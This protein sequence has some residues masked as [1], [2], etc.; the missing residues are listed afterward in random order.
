MSS[1]YS[2]QTRQNF[3]DTNW[4]ASISIYTLGLNNPRIISSNLP[5][6]FSLDYSSGIM[7]FSNISVAHNYSTQL[8]FVFQINVTSANGYNFSALSNPVRIGPTAVQ[9][10][11]TLYNM[12]LT[13]SGDYAAIVSSRQVATYTAMI[14]NLL[15]STYGI[16]FSSALS[17]SS[18]SV[19]IGATAYTADYSA[20]ADGLSNSSSLPSGLIFS[21]VNVNSVTY[22]N[23]ALAASVTAT[24]APTVRNILVFFFFISRIHPLTHL[25]FDNRDQIYQRFSE[26]RECYVFLI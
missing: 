25:F 11:S 20:L 26:D 17:M 5:S 16:V 2:I 21:S 1:S 3:K 8:M 7:G 22:V 12:I 13:F 19:I 15:S 24:P 6:T 9:L 18:G 4:S 14:Y 10:D 23:K